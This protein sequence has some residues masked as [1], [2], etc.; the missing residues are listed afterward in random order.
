[1]D[2]DALALER[3]R[4]ETS[5]AG[6]KEAIEKVHSFGCYVKDLDVGLV[7]FPTR[8]RGEQ[9]L[10]CWKLGEPGIAWWH[11]EQE[12]FRGRKPIDDDFLA[13]HEG[14]EPS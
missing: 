11:G 9:V 2:R 6:L 12:G 8:Y 4:R 14:D 7:D 10:L 13:N 3:A 5:A 1:V